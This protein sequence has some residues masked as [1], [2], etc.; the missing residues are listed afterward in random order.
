[1]NIANGK[2]SRS[3]SAAA[4]AASAAA[5]AAFRSPRARCA[6]PASTCAS[7][8]AYAGR[9]ERRHHALNVSEDSQRRGRVSLCQA[10]CCSRRGQWR[11]S[12]FVFGGELVERGARFVWH[13]ETSLVPQPFGDHRCENVHTGEKRLR[14]HRRGQRLECRLM[15]AATGMQ[16][17]RHHVQQHRGSRVNVCLD[18]FPT[19]AEPS[20]SLLELAHPHRYAG[21]RS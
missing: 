6:R 3:G 2:I 1:M 14:L 18:D 17:T 21:K 9:A 12:A 15:L 19:A 7:T 8:S 4:S 13:P 11:P 16:H 20:L 10:D 5:A